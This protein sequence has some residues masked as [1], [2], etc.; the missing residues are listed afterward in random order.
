MQPK[1]E[2]GRF[3]AIGW[4]RYERRLV[5]PGTFYLEK[6]G[7]RLNVVTCSTNRYDLALFVDREVGLIGPRRRPA[8]ETLSQLDVEKLEVL[9]TPSP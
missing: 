6:G 4:L 7:R 8:T 2:L 1:D 3:Q 9:G 5:G